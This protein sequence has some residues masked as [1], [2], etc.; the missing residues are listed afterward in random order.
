M[1]LRRRGV[2]A[3]GGRGGYL[4]HDKIDFTDHPT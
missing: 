4:S 2:E 3:V 1:R